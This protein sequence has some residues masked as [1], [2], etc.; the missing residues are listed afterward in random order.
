MDAIGIKENRRHSTL[1]QSS[2]WNQLTLS[3]NYSAK[4][5]S[6]F[7]Y[8]LAYIRNRNSSNS[9]AIFLCGDN[10]ATI[11]NEGEINTNQNITLR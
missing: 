5:L 7:G 6:G 10:I 2:L 4:N 3:Q 8:D 1:A 9:T 11:D